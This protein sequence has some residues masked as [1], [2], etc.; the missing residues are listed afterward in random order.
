MVI[1][2]RNLDYY[3]KTRDYPQSPSSSFRAFVIASRHAII[4]SSFTS[5]SPKIS[6]LKDL[7]NN[8]K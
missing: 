1:N 4:Q 2:S 7:D 3:I 8:S 5:F 6:K